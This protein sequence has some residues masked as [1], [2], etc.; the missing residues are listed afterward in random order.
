MKERKRMSI[1]DA[2]DALRDLADE[3]EAT[4]APP[5][6]ACFLDEHWDAIERALDRLVNAAE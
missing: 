2:G 1:E 6:T 3:L 5:F 4:H